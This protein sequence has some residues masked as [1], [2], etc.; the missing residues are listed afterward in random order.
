MKIRILSDYYIVSTGLKKGSIVNEKDYTSFCM[1]AILIKING[2]EWCYVDSEYEF[3]KDL[4][5]IKKK[6]RYKNRV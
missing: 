4:S 1:D 3:V 2:Y 6:R 5:H